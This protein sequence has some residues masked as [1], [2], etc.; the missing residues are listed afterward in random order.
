MRAN[1][2]SRVGKAIMPEFLSSLKCASGRISS[3][4]D[5]HPSVF[6]PNDNAPL[7]GARAAG[8]RA[9]QQCSAI[10]THEACIDANGLPSAMTAKVALYKRGRWALRATRKRLH[11]SEAAADLAAAL[12]G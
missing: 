8:I 2:W 5:G 11:E 3:R 9:P 4:A 12:A 10:A 7:S 6:V 1:D